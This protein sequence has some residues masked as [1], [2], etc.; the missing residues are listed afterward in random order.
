MRSVCLTF[1]FLGLLAACGDDDTADATFQIDFEARVGVRPF[2]CGAIYRAIGSEATEVEPI[3]F[4]FYVH[5]VALVAADGHEVPLALADDGEWQ[6][7]GVALL[8]F[9]DFTGACQDGTA[10]TRT[11]VRGRAPAGTYTGVAFSLGVPE[12][13]NH[14]DLTALPAPLNLSGLYWSWGLGHVFMAVGSRAG[15]HELHVHVGST[16]CAGDPAAGD[17]VTCDRPN[18]TRYVITGFDPT[19]DKLVADWGAIL[20]G[21]PLASADSCHSFPADSCPAP[22]AA[23]GIDFATGAPAAAQTFLR[24]A[25]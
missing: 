25:E 2:E 9:E 11:F 5:D 23:V 17:T 10:E 14:Q 6:Y 20:A 4:R 18:R 21:S 13:L 3:D 22:F 16:G 12:S 15:A 7:Q 1:A 8:D 24:V 19:T